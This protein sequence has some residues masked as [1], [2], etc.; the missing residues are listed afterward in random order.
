MAIYGKSTANNIPLKAERLSAFPLR[1]GTRQEYAL[2][3]VFFNTVLEIPARVTEK[4]KK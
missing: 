3:P 2:S 4:R 1:T